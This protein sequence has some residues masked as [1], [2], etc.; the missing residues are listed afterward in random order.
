MVTGLLKFDGGDSSFFLQRD[1]S[2]VRN[3]PFHQRK[4]VH[5]VTQRPG[6][7]QALRSVHTR[8]PIFASRDVARNY[9]RSYLCVTCCALSRDLTR[10]K[11]QC[12]C[13]R[14]NEA[15]LWQGPLFLNYKFKKLPR[16]TWNIIPMYYLGRGGIAIAQR[17]SKGKIKR[18]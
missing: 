13:K 1:H 2:A 18:I 10:H 15:F 7:V 11:N 5:D 12:L 4:R 6:K 9:K 3:G 14:P 16:E 8:T 17:K